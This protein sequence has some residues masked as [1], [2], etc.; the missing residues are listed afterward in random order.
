MNL[1]KALNKFIMSENGPGTNPFERCM[2][3]TNDTLKACQQICKDEHGGNWLHYKQTDNPLYHS[4]IRD[5]NCKWC[6]NKY[7]CQKEGWYGEGSIPIWMLD[8]LDEEKT[9]CRIKAG[10]ELPKKTMPTEIIDTPS[11]T[12]SAPIDMP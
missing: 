2:S 11:V 1:K 5:C 4:C 6:D 3:K 8:L 12:K 10:C 7:N 9:R